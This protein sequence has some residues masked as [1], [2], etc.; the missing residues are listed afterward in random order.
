MWPSN[1]SARSEA[2]STQEFVEAYKAKYDGEIPNNY[3]AEGYD[4]TWLLARGIKEANSADR[5]AIQ[6]G[7]AK[8]A[9]EGFDGAQG[10]LTFE[11][12]DVRVEGVLASWDGS[13][14]IVIT[15]D[16]S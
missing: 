8:V 6:E 3:A 1:F 16:G 15:L 9:Q 10:P 14:E 2:P 4:A 5:V 7:I 13:E 12:N 11:G